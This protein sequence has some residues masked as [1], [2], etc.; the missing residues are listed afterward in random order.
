[1][2]NM[3]SSISRSIAIDMPLQSRGPSRQPSQADICEQHSPP[4][5]A[6]ECTN[7]RCKARQQTQGQTIDELIVEKEKL[8]AEMSKL[9]ATIT[10]EVSSLYS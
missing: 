10:S 4:R 3:F 8:K 7:F 5:E 2:D 6:E 9:K 1:M